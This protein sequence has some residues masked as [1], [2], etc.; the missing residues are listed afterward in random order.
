MLPRQTPLLLWSA[1]R[2]RQTVAE[3]ASILQ[4]A[5]D[6]LCHNARSNRPMGLI[7][8]AELKTCEV[9][10]PFCVAD[11]LPIAP[12]TTQACD[13]RGHFAHGSRNRGS[14]VKNGAGDSGHTIKSTL[15]T[16]ESGAA[17]EF[18]AASFTLR[19]ADFVQRAF[20]S[21]RASSLHPPECSPVRAVQRGL[22]E[23][24]EPPTSRPAWSTAAAASAAISNVPRFF[25]GTRNAAATATFTSMISN[26]IP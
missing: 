5:P 8:A 11:V 16:F 25:F 20:E 12:V 6:E 4:R 23:A 7:S 21:C 19:S 9:E 3:T 13:A 18:Q 2:Q 22:R 15:P 10:R 26:E 24:R 17:D 1:L 14:F